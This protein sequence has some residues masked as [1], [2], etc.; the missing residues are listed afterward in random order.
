MKPKRQKQEEDHQAAVIRWANEMAQNGGRPELEMLI[1]SM[2]G[3]RLNIGQAVKAK[4][5][6]NRAG[7]P[8]LHLPISRHGYHG[9][10][11]EMKKPKG[12]KVSI[13]QQD[14]A[15]RLIANGHLWRLCNGSGE[16]IRTICDYL[17]IRMVRQ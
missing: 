9:L 5:L 17:D 7:V 3:V 2:S 11:I 16:A 8:D 12:G 13:E 10:W 15:G 14:W 4:R 1:G 6:G